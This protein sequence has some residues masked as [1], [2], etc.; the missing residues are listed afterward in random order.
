MLAKHNCSDTFVR[1]R[2]RGTT[3]R[4]SVV[5]GDAQ[6]SVSA[7]ISGDGR[8]VAFDWEELNVV[9]EETNGVVD[10]FVRDRPK[11]ITALVSVPNSPAPRAGRLLLRPWPARAGK[12]LTA[13]MSVEV[14]GKPAG[15]V[16]VFCA[17]T[18]AGRSLR[19][20]SH[21][22]RAGSARCSWTIPSGARGKPLKGSIAGTTASGTAS[23]P[24]AGTIR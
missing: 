6:D 19:A 24:V 12:Q 21:S 9:A 13:T 17:A 20:G 23:K 15:R 7:A 5:G 3:K 18:L 16:G 4:V 14:G 1:D 22:F 2:V 10:V 8:Y 11:K